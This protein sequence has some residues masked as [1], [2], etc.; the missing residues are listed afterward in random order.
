MDQIPTSILI[1]LF[2]FQ[3]KDAY[4]GQKEAPHWWEK[5]KRAK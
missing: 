3:S 2:L 4:H 5:E 1:I